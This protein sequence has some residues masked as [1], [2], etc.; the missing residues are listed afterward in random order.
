MRVLDPY[1]AA[2]RL[3]L[4]LDDRE[5]EAGAAA[6]AAAPGIDAKEPLEDPVLEPGRDARPGVGDRQLDALLDPARAHRDL[7]AAVLDRVVE[8]VLDH[9]IEAIARREHL[10]CDRDVDVDPR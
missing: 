2:D 7:G 1:P 9:V 4:A 3:D 10:E 5:T 6:V 8:Q